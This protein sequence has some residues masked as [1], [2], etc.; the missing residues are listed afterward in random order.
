MLSQLI[1]LRTTCKIS[2]CTWSSTTVSIWLGQVLNS[3]FSSVT[4]LRNKSHG[5][6]IWPIF[7]IF[8]IVYG[9]QYVESSRSRPKLGLILFWNAPPLLEYDF[10][11]ILGCLAVFAVIAFHCHCFN[12]GYNHSYQESF[13]LI[14]F[15]KATNFA[16]LFDL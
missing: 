7:P 2:S 5:K 6:R 16:L 14:R 15:L 13:R 9:A 11:S 3:F 4:K 1:V 12:F 8:L 10:T